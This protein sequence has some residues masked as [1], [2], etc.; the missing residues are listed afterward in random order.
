MYDEY[1][2][3]IKLKNFIRLESSSELKILNKFLN[4]RMFYPWKKTWRDFYLVLTEA[5][6]YSLL[7]SH[8]ADSNAQ[9]EVIEMLGEF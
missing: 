7:I 4:T 3:K 8:R 6:S 9:E 1:A 5:M 2:K